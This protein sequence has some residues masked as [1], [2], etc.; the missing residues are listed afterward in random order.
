[1]RRYLLAAILFCIVTFIGHSEKRP[2][3][4]YGQKAED[5]YSLGNLRDGLEYA[6]QEISDY[7][8]N[9]NGYYQA[10]LCLYG[11]NEPG[12]ALSMLNKAIDL[13]KKDKKLQAQYL[14]SLSDLLKE[15]GDTTESISALDKALKLDPKNV[16]LLLDHANQITEID[17]QRALKELQQAEKLSPNNPL[18][19]S[20]K[21]YIYFTQYKYEEALDETTRAITL[22]NKSAF[23]YGLRGAL[24]KYLDYSPDWIQDCLRSF[25]LE[26]ESTIGAI[27]LAQADSEADQMAIIDEIERTKTSFNGYYPLEAEL[28]YEWG[29]YE[30]AAKIYQQMIDLN[31][32]D[33]ETYAYLAD[34]LQRTGDYLSAFTILTKG[35]EKY[36]DNNTLSF[37]KALI[38]IE[39]GKGREVLDVIDDFISRNPEN[40]SPYSAKG[41]ALMSI[42]QYSEAVEPFHIAVIIDPSVRNKIF[43]ADALRL[44]GNKSKSDAEYRD[45]LNKSQEEIEKENLSPYYAFAMAYSGLG[46]KENAMK[47]L[48]DYSKIE[49]G[50]DLALFPMVY[51]RLGEKSAAIEALRDYSEKNDWSPLSDLY[52]YDF[53]PLHTEPEF[54]DLLT[55]KGVGTIRNAE[56]GLLEYVPD[57]IDLSSGG[58]SLEEAQKKLTENPKDFIKIVNQLCPIDLGSFGQ[59]TSVKF[60]EKTHTINYYYL[61]TPRSL[62][63]DALNNN[64]SYKR[65]KEEIIGLSNFRNWKEAIESGYTFV[66]N[67]EAADNSGK[68]TFKFTP[69][70]I[71]SIT[72]KYNSQ[73]EIDRLTL[74]FWCEEENMGMESKDGEPEDKVFFDGKT[75]TYVYPVKDEEGQLAQMDLFYNETKRQL[76][77]LFKDVA[78]KPRLSVFIRQN[79]TIEFIYRD[80]KTGKEVKFSFPVEELMDYVN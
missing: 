49:D 14:W 20:Y 71:K 77:S 46:D 72:K 2:Y 7:E 29:Q 64:A 58:T 40:P 41:Q 5:A 80:I 33:E 69:E 65:Q 78:L 37:Q 31:I 13:A 8:K 30:G 74:E 36:P 32:A 34:C 57:D 16:D 22:D 42:G 70:K 53:Y 56:T 15:L 61:T 21:A 79:I 62:N 43:Y 54:V 59:L 48:E 27:V 67:Y 73:D 18:V 52:S 60:D 23:N 51:A 12:R 47:I 19:H 63:Y 55:E 66:Y 25:E 11:L 17:P 1:M 68:T 39:V 28:L 3:D 75:Y 45:I 9:P 76:G 24:L 35:L 38:G 26:G 10:C 6:L 50:A 4:Y 44:S